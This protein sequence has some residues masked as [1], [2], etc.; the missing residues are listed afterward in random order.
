MFLLKISKNVKSP[1]TKRKIKII[2]NTV[3][4]SH[5]LC[6]NFVTEYFIFN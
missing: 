1:K 4:Y 5:K 3:K 2:I 6:G